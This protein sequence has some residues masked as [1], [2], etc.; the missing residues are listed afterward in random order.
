[1]QADNHFRILIV[2]WTTDFPSTK[3]GLG[4]LAVGGRCNFNCLLHCSNTI[5][6]YW[7]WLA[8]LSPGR[9]SEENEILQSNKQVT[10]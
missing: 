3:F 6:F 2:D 8:I 7:N 10:N 5:G 9:C 1:M 4:G